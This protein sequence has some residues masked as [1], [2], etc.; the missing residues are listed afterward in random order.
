M[1]SSP[2]IGWLSRLVSR[3]VRLDCLAEL[4]WLVELDGPVELDWPAEKEHSL[5]Q[6]TEPG[7]IVGLAPECTLPTA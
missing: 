2:V 7:C 4:D 6:A 1:N 3:L 5:S